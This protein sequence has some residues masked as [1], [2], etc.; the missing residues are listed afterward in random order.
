MEYRTHATRTSYGPEIDRR[1][2]QLAVLV[3]QLDATIAQS[4]R[5]SRGVDALLARIDNTVA[6]LSQ[7]TSALDGVAA[8]PRPIGTLTGPARAEAQPHRTPR[9]ARRA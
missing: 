2:Q 8:W 9:T 3:R 6:E 4:H 5:D 1:V 7:A